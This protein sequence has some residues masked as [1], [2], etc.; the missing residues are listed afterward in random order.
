MRGRS[1]VPDETAPLEV[2]SSHV[3][4]VHHVIGQAT[5][6]S[7]AEQRDQFE[8]LA[9]R[10]EILTRV[11][12]AQEAAAS[13]LE[14][15]EFSARASHR[16][17]ASTWR[18]TALDCMIGFVRGALRG[19]AHMTQPDQAN[20]SQPTPALGPFDERSSKVSSGS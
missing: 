20:T 1:R 5:P 16:N 15:Q 12:P 2:Q 3:S 7:E 18:S 4:A 8:L 11:C 10:Q 9:I 19:L 14:T 6:P 17:Q 13:D